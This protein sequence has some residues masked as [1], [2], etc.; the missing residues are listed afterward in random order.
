MLYSGILAEK[1]GNKKEA[2]KI[3]KAVMNNGNEDHF[4]CIK[5]LARI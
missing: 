4:R 5:E 1:E 3:F 2:I